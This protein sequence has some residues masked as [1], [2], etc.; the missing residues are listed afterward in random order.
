MHEDLLILIKLKK[1]KETIS[2][3]LITKIKELKLKM[4]D[5]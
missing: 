1:R 3:K 4:K 2:F 5:F